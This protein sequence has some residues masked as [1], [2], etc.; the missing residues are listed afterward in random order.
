MVPLA[1]QSNHFR[2]WSYKITEATITRTR[3]R[4]VKSDIFEVTHRSHVKLCRM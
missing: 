2:K 4:S 3:R 1:Y